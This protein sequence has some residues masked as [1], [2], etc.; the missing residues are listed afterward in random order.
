MQGRSRL[1]LETRPASVQK[2]ATLVIK[3][4][5]RVTYWRSSVFGLSGVRP[6][7]C[8]L[9]QACLTLLSLSSWKL[10][11]PA[12]SPTCLRLYLV[13]SKNQVLEFVCPDIY[14]YEECHKVQETTLKPVFD[15][16]I[17]LE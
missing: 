12:C 3:V 9:R 11:S 16:F 14:M 1:L 10:S 5:R 4:V 7:P 8:Y 2:V 6:C 17:P 13:V 15:Q